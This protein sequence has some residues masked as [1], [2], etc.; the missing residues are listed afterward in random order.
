[1]PD[2][3]ID[4]GRTMEGSPDGEQH[5]PSLFLEWDDK[6]DLPESGTMT[7]KFKRRS[8][9]NEK[10]RDGK[11]RQSV[12]LD[13]TQIENVEANEEEPEKEE[14]SGEALDKAVKSRRKRKAKLPKGED[15]TVVAIGYR[16]DE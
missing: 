5:F 2:M 3:P 6:Y 4:L 15:P 10:T 7:V 1:M 9:K 11:Q 8:E 14:D 12:E 16:E 13:I